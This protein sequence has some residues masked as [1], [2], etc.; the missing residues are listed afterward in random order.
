[1]HIN[2]CDDA[3]NLFMNISWACY[4]C[5]MWIS[6]KCFAVIFN[7]YLSMNSLV[8]LTHTVNE[9]NRGSALAPKYVSSTMSMCYWV[10]L[11]LEM[12]MWIYLFVWTD[13]MENS[14]RVVNRQKIHRGFTYLTVCSVRYIYKK[15]KKKMIW[16]CVHQI[17]KNCNNTQQ[18]LPIS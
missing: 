5:A 11:R 4:E 15:K 16:K 12:I 14:C 17:C 9:K 13:N 1:M 3:A 18:H 2:R 8:Q 10:K 6:H 7:F